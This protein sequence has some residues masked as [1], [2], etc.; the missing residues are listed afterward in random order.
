MGSTRESRTILDD[1]VPGLGERLAQIDFSRLEA[2]SSIGLGIYRESKATG[3]LVD[4]RHGGLGASAYQALH[5]TRALGSIAP[6]LA[7]AVTMHNFSVAALN[8]IEEHFDGVEWMVLDAVANDGLFMSSGFAEGRSGQGFLSPTMTARRKG[9]HWIVNGSKRPCSLSRSMDLMSAS[10]S[11][12]GDDGESQIGVLVIPSTIDGLTV[13]PFWNASVLRAAES[14]EVIL[15]DVEVPDELVMKPTEG[16]GITLEELEAKG[17]TWFTLLIT[18]AYVGM[19]GAL[20]D[21]LLESGKGTAHARTAAA[22]AIQATMLS[23]E[24]VARSIDDPDDRSDRLG[25]ALIARYAAQ[26]AIVRTVGVV[27]ET[28]GGIEFITNPAISYL[29]SATHALALHPPSRN[30]MVGELEGS[31]LGRPISIA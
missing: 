9:A 12:I 28:L 25:G 3:M 29:A 14:D 27:V 26:D 22:C 6:S 15:T 11:L 24:S 21:R 1:V 16:M 10:V 4:R 20:V 7:V 19:A 5:C 23:L 8:S 18:A 31:F 30:S 17:L 13:R 2:D